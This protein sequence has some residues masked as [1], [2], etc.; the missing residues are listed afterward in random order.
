MSDIRSRVARGLSCGLGML[1]L[2]VF[3]SCAARLGDGTETFSVP[4]PTEPKGDLKDLEIDLLKRRLADSQ[5]KHKK[6]KV[7]RLVYQTQVEVAAL[8]GMLPHEPVTHEKLTPEV[9][10][11]L[12]KDSFERQYPGRSLDLSVWLY[13]VFGALPAGTD[14]IA[15]LRDLLGEQAAG[16]YD[17][18]SR[19]LYVS[20]DYK[21]D[22]TMGRMVLAHEIHH[23]LQDQNY[24]LLEMG[25]EDEQNED[26][27]MSLL[28]IIEGDATLLM[29]EH[30]M[31]YG[32]PM[33]FFADLP[34]YFMMDQGKFNA[35]P[36]AIQKEM[37][38]PYLE[39]SNFFTQLDGRTRRRPES[40]PNSFE[41]PDPS[42]RN[43]VFEDPPVSTEQILHP[44]KYLAGEQPAPVEAPPVPTSGDSYQTVVGEFGIAVLLAPT[45][46]DP[47][48]KRAAAGWNGDRLLITENAEVTHRTLHW[49]TRWD[50]A[51]D[52]GEF[53][54]ALAD[55]FEQLLGEDLI[56]AIDNPNRTG[57]TDEATVE[58]TRPAED[59]VA[60]HGTFQI[61]REQ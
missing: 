2:L 30:M 24:H 41:I 35:A 36:P 42:W 60:L 45:L 29:S 4:A 3:A 17:P 14:I 25:I 18:H 54:Q 19:K 21:L 53:L 61:Q 50:N 43:Q 37:L 1:A 11:H 55:A 9:L 46:G 34:G 58:L 13:E 33:G 16:I 44:E 38:F 23:A 56:W 49:I 20:E 51:P 40:D 5:E 52:A 28:A 6:E 27:S 39:G 26:L 59:T 10:D 22:S 57:R 31:R 32:N 7:A 15:L 47:A 12:V 8:R 48:A